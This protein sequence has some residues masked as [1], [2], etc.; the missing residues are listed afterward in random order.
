MTR[1]CRRLDMVRSA[2]RCKEKAN[3][4]KI[5]FIENKIEQFGARMENME[6]TLLYYLTVTVKIIRLG[7]FDLVELSDLQFLVGGNENLIIYLG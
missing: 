2:L 4:T 6:T 3:H 5:H 1:I 7:D